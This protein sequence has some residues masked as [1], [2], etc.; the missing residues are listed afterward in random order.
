MKWLQVLLFNTYYFIWR[1]SFIRTQSNGSK[2]FYVIPVF[3]F[4]QIVKEFQVFLSITNNSI[5][6]QSFVYT[7]LNE[8]TVLFLRIH[9]SI[10]HLFAH[11]LNVKEFYLTHR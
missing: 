9:F 10:S 4:W 5:K 7:Q 11:S 8:L 3:L 1:Y 2:Y 6:R